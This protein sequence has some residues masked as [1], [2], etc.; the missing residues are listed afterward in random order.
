[1]IAHCIHGVSVRSYCSDCAMGETAVRHARA[2]IHDWGRNPDPEPGPSRIREFTPTEKAR[3]A[4]AVEYILCHT[5][6]LKVP[7]E[8]VAV[9]TVQVIE[10][11]L[12][13]TLGDMPKREA[14]TQ[15]Y[16]RRMARVLGYN[17]GQGAGTRCEYCFRVKEH[18]DNRYCYSCFEILKMGLQ[19][20]TQRT[21]TDYDRRVEIRPYENEDVVPMK[22]DWWV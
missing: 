18:S 9:L 3:M 12:R 10:A 15:E 4:E 1:M 14:D 11:L 5:D 8:I 21:K 20:K 22:P 17:L 16:V 7:A 13:D 19:P 2:K 6:Q